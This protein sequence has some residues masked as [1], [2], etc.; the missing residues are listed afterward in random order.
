[1]QKC[2]SGYTQVKYPPMLP[3]VLLVTVK[4]TG[5][6]SEGLKHTFVQTFIES[7]VGLIF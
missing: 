7:L 1:M 4:F 5:R 2:D 3:R 6:A